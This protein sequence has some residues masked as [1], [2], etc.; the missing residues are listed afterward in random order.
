MTFSQPVSYL[1]QLFAVAILSTSVCTSVIAQTTNPQ[2]LYKLSEIIHLDGKHLE[3]PYR[4]Y[5]YCMDD[6]TLMFSYNPSPLLNAPFDFSISNPDRKPLVFT[7]ELSKT[8]NRGIQII[9]TSDS[10]FTLRWYNDRGAFNEHLFPSNTNIDEVYEQ[11]KDS[12]D[13]IHRALNVLKMKDVKGNNRLLGS[14]KLRGLQKD[15][16]AT[17]QYWVNRSEENQYIIFSNNGAVIVNTNEKF[18]NANISCHYAPCKYLSENAV[19]LKDQTWLINWIDYETI[20]TTSFDNDGRPLVCLWDR[21]GLPANFQQ[22]F[23]SSQAPMKKD[24]SRFMNDEFEKRYG[25]QPDSI[26]KAYETF[27]YAIDVTEKNNAV[28]PVL[29]KCGFEDEYKEMKSALLEELMSGKKSADEAVAHYTFWFYKNFDRHTNCS[30]YAFWALQQECHPDYR[31]LIG[32]YAPEPVA[33]LVDK[34]TY[35]LRLPSSSGD[36]PT[37]EWVEKKAEEFLQSGCKYLILDLRGNGGGDDYIS[38]IF[39]KFMCDSGAMNDEDYFYRVSSENDK[40]LAMA[41][42]SVPDNFFDRVWEES[43][44]A[45]EG[46]LINWISFRKGG[47]MKPMV[48]NGAIIVDA[49][50]TSAAETPVRFVHNH[51][52]KHAKVYGRD[53]T[54]GCEQTGNCNSIRLPHSH[55]TMSY[56]TTVDDTFERQ[57]RDKNPGYKPDVIIPLPYPKQLTDNIDP[58]VLWVAKKMK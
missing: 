39:T 9:G 21:C 36:V 35:L 51:S 41:C 13:R 27:N 1:K 46:S 7:G 28:F 48:R 52:K 12:T 53:N 55:I 18:P 6:L 58:W 23:G 56:P 4:Q 15:N 38:L 45:E 17:T 2:G 20:S 11:V 30:A 47:E 34:E 42:E 32:N 33:C 10:T 26:R 22:V 19:D 50:S 5:K 40:R 57:C 43:K 24:I 16:I 25:A 29:I 37:V 31:K 54:M 44:T 8:E 49:Y 14:W 3:A